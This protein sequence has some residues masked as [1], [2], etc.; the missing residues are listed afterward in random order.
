M[1]ARGLLLLSAFALMTS[2][3]REARATSCAKC[4]HLTGGL[5]D[6][7]SARAFT[8]ASYGT[9]IGSGAI[10]VGNTFF[11]FGSLFF[12]GKDMPKL[13][14]MGAY[15]FAG[16][17]IL[18]GICASA[19]G[20]NLQAMWAKVPDAH[21]SAIDRG[22]LAMAMGLTSLGSSALNLVTTIV[23]QH[24]G[25]RREPTLRVAPTVTLDRAGA[26]NPGVAIS[27]RW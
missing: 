26:L 11:A 3:A 1:F 16:G 13:W 21:P 6:P 15:F 17:G 5:V 10:A 12:I 18:L 23:V 8:D 14:Y 9:A 22:T 27:T 19:L 4:E 25:G 24:A 2:Y 20:A 7:E